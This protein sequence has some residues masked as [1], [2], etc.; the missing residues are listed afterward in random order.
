MPLHPDSLV[1]DFSVGECQL[2]EIIRC[3]LKTSDLII[4]DE[5]ISVLTLQEADK[6]FETLGRL[7]SEGKSIFYIAYRLDEVCRLY[8]GAMARL[9]A[10]ATISFKTRFAGAA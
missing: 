10:V 2:V 6:L 7:R 5:P 4:F 8:D 3:L 9:S 1:G